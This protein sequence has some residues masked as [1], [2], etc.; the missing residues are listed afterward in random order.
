M[1]LPVRVMR[2]LE[3]ITEPASFTRAAPSWARSSSLLLGHRADAAQHLGVGVERVGGEV[4]ADRVRLEA[5]T[6]PCP[7]SPAEAACAAPRSGRHHRTGRSDQLIFSSAVAWARFSIE[8]GTGEQAGAV[9][10]DRRRR[11]RR[12]RGSRSASC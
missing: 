12:G 5:E 11:R 1:R 9:G 3:L 10:L 8:I 7:P 6:V 2:S 4:E